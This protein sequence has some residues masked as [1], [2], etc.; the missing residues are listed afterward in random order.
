MPTPE[1][2]QSNGCQRRVAASADVFDP[3]GV[4]GT[5]GTLYRWY[6]CAQP[7]ANRCN[8]SGV[9]TEV[10]RR[11]TR[12]P[13]SDSTDDQ[14]AETPFTG[15]NTP[16]QPLHF[17]LQRPGRTPGLIMATP[18]EWLGKLPTLPFHR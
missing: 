12:R 3:S 2:S 5:M 11:A 1:G 15:R 16:P 7:P 14:N 13:S 9:R 6:R 8:P 4:G 18:D 10:A 17:Q